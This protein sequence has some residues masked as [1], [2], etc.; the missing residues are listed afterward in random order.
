[1]RFVI[2][3]AMSVVLLAGCGG[4]GGSCEQ[5]GAVEF[6]YTPSRPTQL[7]QA[8]TYQLGRENAW[9]LQVRGVSSECLKGLHASVPAGRPALP[10]GVSLDASTGQIRTGVLNSAIEGQC[11]T[12][13]GTIVG[14]SAN[15]R[16]SSGQ[17][18]EDVRYVLLITTDSVNN[19]SQVPTPVTFEPAQ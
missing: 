1:M 14:P 8:L 18:Y 5:V 11:L 10:A 13:T 7:G 16:C 15:R 4:G 12:S 2:V 6:V 17:V 3:V 19:Q 9:S